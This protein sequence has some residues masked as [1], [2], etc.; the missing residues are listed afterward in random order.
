L[1]QEGIIDWWCTEHEEAF[2][3]QRPVYLS[4]AREIRRVCGDDVY[5]ELAAHCRARQ[6]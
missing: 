1:G 4:M 5:S 2:G 3:A 6:R